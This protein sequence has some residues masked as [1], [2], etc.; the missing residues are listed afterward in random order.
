MARQGRG[1]RYDAF[2]NGQIHYNG[3]PCKKCGNTLRY[4]TKVEQW[5]S[6]ICQIRLILAGRAMILMQ[7]QQQ[8]QEREQE[9]KKQEEKK[10]QAS[11]A[12]PTNA[13][14]FN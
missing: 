8:Q 6:E 1:A 12:S 14:V 4:T 3:A 9:E 5:T 10:K 11:Q 13:M 7:Q 2:H